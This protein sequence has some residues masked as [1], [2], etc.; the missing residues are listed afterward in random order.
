MTIVASMSLLFGIVLGLRF[1]VRAL[2]GLCLVVMV[3][4][5]A[6]A[7]T[8]FYPVGEAALFAVSTTVA[9]QVGYFVSMVIG[10]M[11]LTET[12]E[13]EPTTSTERPRGWEMPR[14]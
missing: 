6:A 12:P 14:G 3:A 5:I 2:F 7:L 10:A 13:R 11:Q 4:G 1:N 8:G 9:L